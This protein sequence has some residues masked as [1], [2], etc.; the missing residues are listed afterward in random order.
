MLFHIWINKLNNRIAVR[1]Q[2]FQ[3]FKQLKFPLYFKLDFSKKTT[4]INLNKIRI[5]GL[6]WIHFFVLN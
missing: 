6:V 5:Y 1:V 2:Q 4:L 3:K